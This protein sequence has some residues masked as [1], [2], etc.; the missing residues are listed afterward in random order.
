MINSQSAAVKIT[1]EPVN[2]APNPI[3]PALTVLQNTSGTVTIDPNDPDNRSGTEQTHRFEILAH[4]QAEVSANG[5]VIYT[6]LPDFIGTDVIRVRVTDSGHPPRSSTVEVPVSVISEADIDLIAVSGNLQS[7]RQGEP[8]PTPFVVLMVDQFGDPVIG[9]DVTVEVARGDGTLIVDDIDATLRGSRQINGKRRQLTTDAEGKVRFNLEVGGDVIG[10]DIG[11]RVSAGVQAVEL[12]TIIGSVDTPGLPLDVVA[13]E[14]RAYI[15]DGRTGLQV[16]DVSNP[17]QPESGQSL[18]LCGDAVRLAI[19]DDLAYVATQSP[20]RLYIV[21]LAQLEATSPEP[22]LSCA[23]NRRSKP[24]AIL[25]WADFCIENQSIKGVAVQDATVYVATEIVF[26]EE[27]EADQNVDLGTIQVVRSSVVQALRDPNDS[28]DCSDADT[29]EDC[30]IDIGEQDCEFP[31]RVF[32]LSSRPYDIA[33]F[34]NALYVP[35]GTSGLNVFEVMIAR[36]SKEISLV[37]QDVVAGNFSSGVALG[38]DGQ[39][40]YAYLVES[41]SGQNLFT[42]LDLRDPL[43]PSLKGSVPTGPVSQGADASAIAANEQFAF[44]VQG[45]LGLRAIDLADRDAPVLASRARTPTVALNTAVASR[46]VY[47]TDQSFGLQVMAEPGRQSGEDTDGDGI[48]NADD[49]DDDNDTYPD[50][51]EQA[52][53]P[54]TDP[55]E[56]GSFPVNPPSEGAT[57][58]V[59]AATTTPATLRNGAPATPYRSITEGLRGLLLAGRSEP[60]GEPITLFVRAG[61]YSAL[62]TNEQF[63]LDLS[64]LPN[65]TL[66]SETG[67][68]ATVIDAGWAADVVVATP[69]TK[70]TYMIEGFT[71][72]HGVTGFVGSNATIALRHS[73]LADH[74]ADGLRVSGDANAEIHDTIITD[75]GNAGIVVIESESEMHHNTITGNTDSGILIISGL[76]T[77]IRDNRISRNGSHGISILSGSTGM[78]GNNRQRPKAIMKNEITDNMVDGINVRGFSQVEI[79]DNEIVSNTD[80]GITVFNF[81]NVTIASNT[82]HGQQDSGISVANGGKA[83]ISGNTITHNHN[84]GIALLSRNRATTINDNSITENIDD[85]ISIT[86]RAQAD[87]DNNTIEN[88]GD[89]GISVFQFSTGMITKNIIKGHTDNGISVSTNSDSLISENMISSNQDNGVRVYQSSIAAITKNIIENQQNNGVYLVN[90]S[91]AVLSDNM[92]KSNINNGIDMLSKSTAMINS[93][94]FRNNDKNGILIRN[95]STASIKHNTIQYHQEH[96]INIIRTSCASVD[97]G[98]ISQETGKGIFISRSNGRSTAEINKAGIIFAPDRPRHNISGPFQDRTMPRD[99]DLD[100]DGILDGE[101]NCPVVS[102]EDQTDADGDGA[103]DACD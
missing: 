90:K 44:V 81:A 61:T 19:E 33:L 26:D 17:S 13:L 39:D 83:A 78:N 65:L 47:V 94:T 4:D 41:R 89:D 73:V 58:V 72:I 98:L 48:V 62:T 46:V 74:L 70:S 76:K 27:V 29:P 43:A 60:S 69:Q 57:L 32:P 63:P 53:M 31:G 8:L 42:V 88:N 92:I 84:D 10:D 52:A 67:R 18:Q 45:A 51:A 16:I 56:P 9:V 2:D 34:D 36:F 54:P 1:V 100:G 101:D 97:G 96:G 14:D 87:V 20:A 99:C 102:N 25:G 103:G 30:E 38:R 3:A 86:S 35:S 24:A 59:D 37:L 49:P 5:R 71:L 22:V 79:M 6:P 12:L 23:D 80:D 77:D 66:K 55:L 64:A 85:G 68:E 50:D 15:A 82:I 95:H 7:G 93:N 28:Q 11:V 40:H 75:N 91:Q 21:D